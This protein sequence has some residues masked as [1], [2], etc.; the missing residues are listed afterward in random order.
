VGKSKGRE[1]SIPNLGSVLTAQIGIFAFDDLAAGAAARNTWQSPLFVQSNIVARLEGSFR[2]TS[3]ANF[4]CASHRPLPHPAR[5]RLRSDFRAPMR[6]HLNVLSHPTS[7]SGPSFLFKWE[8]AALLFEAP[9]NLSRLCT[10]QRQ[11]LRKVNGLFVSSLKG[12]HGLHGTIMNLDAAGKRDL[13]LYGPPNL[14]HYMACARFHLR[15]FV[16]DAAPIRRRH[17]LC[18]VELR[19]RSAFTRRGRA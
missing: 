16:G 6:W 7:D 14:D 11:S 17:H 1:A 4:I 12:S 18:Q 5:K 15:R 2:H 19:V 13:D 10:Q 9:E 3:I 8:T